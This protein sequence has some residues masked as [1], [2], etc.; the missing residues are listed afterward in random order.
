MQPGGPMPPNKTAT[1]LPSGRAVY[2]ATDRRAAVVT[3]WYHHVLI[4]IG[5]GPNPAV[6][7]AILDSIA[8]SPTLPDTAVLGRC[9]TAEPSPPTMPAPTR[10]TAPLAPDDGNAQMQPEPPTVQPR[11][12]AASV[13]AGLFHHFGASA[14]PGPLQWSIVFGSYS[15]HT[16]ATINPDGSTTPDFQRVPTWLIR[17]AGIMTPFGSCGKTVLAPYNADTGRGM[18]V[19]TTG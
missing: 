1:V 2:L 5:I 4:Q 16:P 12:S 19:E 11:V 15:A 10:L 8:F 13:W 7:G 9:P 6:E 14:F 18:G 3:V 17:G